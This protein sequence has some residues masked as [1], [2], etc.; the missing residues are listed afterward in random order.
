VKVP[1]I[2]GLHKYV[3]VVEVLVKPGDT[4][5][6]EDFRSSPWNRIKRR[7]NTVAWRLV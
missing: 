2:G 6:P 7:S 4:V 5:Q 3:P 1:D